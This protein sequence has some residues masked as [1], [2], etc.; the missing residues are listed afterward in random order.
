MPNLANLN[1]KRP[2]DILVI[3]DSHAHPDYHNKRFDWL[4]ELIV[5]L[6]PDVVVDIGDMADMPSLCSYD[7]GTKGFEGRRYRKDVAAMIDAQERINAPIKRQKR[8]VPTR[9][10][11]TGNHE[12][13]IARAVE[14]DAVLEGVISIDDL[15]GKEHGW[16]VYPFLDIVNINGVHFSHY[17]VTGA[18]GRPAVSAR[19][20]LAK[21][22]ESCVMGHAHTY[23]YAIIP[24]V[25][26][27]HRH[28]L[29][30]GVY[31]DFHAD[32][33]GQANGHWRR[34]VSMLRDVENGDFDL[35][36]ISLERIKR[37][38]G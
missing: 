9:I 23:D 3:P 18:M 7:K 15:Q 19:A 24:S 10:R 34:G 26:G 30:T 38:Y 2:I 5:D 25:S 14:R 21:Q 20:M 28:G 36:W 17:F 6:K 12:H 4:G 13:R 1:L 33:A 8:K 11:T 16:E 31:Q 29:I 32:F 27:A 35:E 22:G 37:A